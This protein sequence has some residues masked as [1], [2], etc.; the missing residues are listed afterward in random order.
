MLDSFFTMGGSK[1]KLL[2][3]TQYSYLYNGAE[4]TLTGATQ[5]NIA[6]WTYY[7]APGS[8]KTTGNGISILSASG[9]TATVNMSGLKIEW[10]SID[11]IPLGG[12]AWSAGYTSGVGN[13]TCTTGS[14]CAVD[15]AYALTYGNRSGRRPFRHWRRLSTTSNCTGRWARFRRPRPTA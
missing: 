1:E 2:L 10:N 5:S 12:L 3:G 8:S 6:T 15:S 9:D 7:D 4:L 14:G 13:I 11:A